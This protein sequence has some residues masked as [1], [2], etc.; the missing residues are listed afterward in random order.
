MP[1]VPTVYSRSDFRTHGLAF[2]V[3]L[4]WLRELKV[5]GMVLQKVP[6]L[7]KHGLISKSNKLVLQPQKERRKTRERE[8]T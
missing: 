8:G 4:S 1:T 2:T 3:L 5:R 7:Y 6:R